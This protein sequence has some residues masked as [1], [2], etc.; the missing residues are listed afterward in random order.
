MT[1]KEEVI[2]YVKE[3]GR[4]SYSAI[5]RALGRPDKTIY[6]TLRELLDS[7][8]LEKDKEGLYQIGRG[9]YE[10]QEDEELLLNARR[11]ILIV[12]TYNLVLDLRYLLSRS[13]NVSVEERASVIDA[14]EKLRPFVSK[15]TG[16]DE[17]ELKRNEEKEIRIGFAEFVTGAV[18][19]S[20]PLVKKGM[21]ERYYHILRLLRDHPSADSVKHVVV[22]SL[23]TF[24][25]VA[26]KHVGLADLPEPR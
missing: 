4:A 22:D 5:A 17:K 18:V 15:Y 23:S 14:I 26:V 1:V 25:A 16:V 8:I 12:R 6:V 13:F 11:K 24:K 19:W 2:N 20:K 21:R 7:G 10:M 9:Y 3:K